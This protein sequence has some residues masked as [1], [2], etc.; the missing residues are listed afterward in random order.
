[1]TKSQFLICSASQKW[2]CILCCDKHFTCQITLLSQVFSII[3]LTLGKISLSINANTNK[4][5]EE[6]N[7]INIKIIHI[8]SVDMSVLFALLCISGYLWF[9]FQYLQCCFFY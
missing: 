9:N 6:E 2:E 4:N 1:M 7:N 5:L 8:F 3:L